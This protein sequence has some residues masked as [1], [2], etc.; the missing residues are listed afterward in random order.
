MEHTLLNYIELLSKN[1]G[2]ISNKNALIKIIINETKIKIW[3]VETKD[4]LITAGQP[5]EWAKIGLVYSDPYI[6]IL[7]DLVEFP[8]GR[9]GSYFRLINQ[10]DLQGGQGVVILASMNNKYLLLR[11]YR[12]PIRSWS[13][14]VPRG[15]GEP[16]TSAEEQAQTEIREEVEGEISKLFDLGIYFNNTGL[17]GN[18]VKLFFA[19][20]ASIGRPAKEEGIESL[21]WVSLKELEDMI[22]NAQ[23]TDGFT[24]AAYTRAKLRGLLDT[25]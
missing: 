21:Y 11:Q 10:A 4:K 16:G 23:I 18:K 19:K 3:E 22:A 12:H 14:E 5:P 17:E 7:R 9:I 1:P 20:L 25:N 15:F 24:I 13:F 6:I 8:G 2:L